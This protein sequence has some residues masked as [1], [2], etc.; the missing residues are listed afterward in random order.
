MSDLHVWIIVECCAC[1]YILEGVCVCV[2]IHLNNCVKSSVAPLP[3]DARFNVV[4]GKQPGYTIHDTLPPAVVVLFENVQH[5]ALLETQ[6]VVLI[7]IVI[8]NCDH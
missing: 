5:G 6:F 4:A 2:L 7:R 8:V 3:L 1:V